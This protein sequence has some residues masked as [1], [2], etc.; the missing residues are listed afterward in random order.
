MNDIDIIGSADESP[1]ERSEFS[2]QLG[3]RSDSLFSLCDENRPPEGQ[4][5]SELELSKLPLDGRRPRKPQRPSIQ[6]HLQQ[7]ERHRIAAAQSNC[8]LVSAVQMRKKSS[9]RSRA[10]V[11]QRFQDRHHDSGFNTGTSRSSTCNGTPTGTTPSHVKTSHVVSIAALKAA[12]SQSP[13]SYL[14]NGD[15]YPTSAAAAAAASQ[16]KTVFVSEYI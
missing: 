6:Q 7:L 2:G 16:S 9:R 5:R 10:A 15:V 3:G 12:L 14:D 11:L 13:M 8:S 1:E 4:S